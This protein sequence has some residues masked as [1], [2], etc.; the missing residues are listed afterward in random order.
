[1]AIV[2]HM[3]Y[4]SWPKK[5]IC[6]ERPGAGRHRSAKDILAIGCRSMPGS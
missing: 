5:V 3:V 2:M 4:F 6:Q 1:M